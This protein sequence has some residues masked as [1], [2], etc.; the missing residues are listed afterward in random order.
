MKAIV[1]FRKSPNEAA[2][3]CY[4]V[5]GNNYGR[6]DAIVESYRYEKGY[7]I[8]QVKYNRYEPKLQ[9]LMNKKGIS[10]VK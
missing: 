6:I 3:E 10:Y 7:K 1:A 9:H 2:S 8:S 4:N 5:S